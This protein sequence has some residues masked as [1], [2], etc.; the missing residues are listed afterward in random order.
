MP[1]AIAPDGT[2]IAYQIKGTGDP[3][4]LVSGQGFDRR[5]WDGIAED[6]SAQFAVIQF[7]LRGTGE[8][9]APETPA[10]T[11]RGFAADTVAVLDAAGIE[12]AHAYGFSMGGRVCQWLAIDHGHRVGALVLGGTTPGN[13]HGIARAPE[14]TA[15]LRTGDMMGV[16][17][18]MVSPEFL[19]DNPS[20]FAPP[21]LPAYV[22]RLHF[23]ASE[24]HDCWDLLPRI[25]A[26]TLV[27]HGADDLVNPTG[28]AHLL[29]DRIPRAE[30]VL[31]RGGRH[32]YGDEFRS[33]ANRAV[34][35]FL[36]RHPLDLR[37]AASDVGL[38]RTVQ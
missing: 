36:T 30:L 12:R 11:T 2:R 17:P 38:E 4:I 37:A 24:G 20:A 22:R 34:T 15:L 8:S 5:M 1:F 28:N 19:A 6:L 23:Q 25:V 29:A 3:L 35:G 21:D 9:D 7:D 26:P 10:Y 13:A 16:A 33:E 18:L 32:F 31:I 14:V 27:I